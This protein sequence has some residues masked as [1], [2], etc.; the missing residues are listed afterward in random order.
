MYAFARLILGPLFGFAT[1]HPIIE[2]AARQ[3]HCHGQAMG[4]LHCA[5]PGLVE[6]SMPPDPEL[7]DLIEWA[8]V[9]G[10]IDTKTAALA[11]AWLVANRFDFAQIATHS[12]TQKRKGYIPKNIT[13]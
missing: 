1:E 9:D 7:V 11:Y 13:L 3:V 12:A 4:R 6:A 5:L 2:P 8:F 10:Q